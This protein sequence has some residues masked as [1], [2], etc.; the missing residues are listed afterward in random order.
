VLQN[1]DLDAAQKF[2]TVACT[3]SLT[4]PLAG[5]LVTTKTTLSVLLLVLLSLRLLWFVRQRVFGKVLLKH[6]TTLNSHLIDSTPALH[7]T[8]P[9]VVYECLIFVPRITGGQQSVHLLAEVERATYDTVVRDKPCL[10]HTGKRAYCITKSL[11]QPTEEALGIRSV[12][13]I[14]TDTEGL[15]SDHYAGHGSSNSHAQLVS[16]ATKVQRTGMGGI[17]ETSG[18]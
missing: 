6:C 5:D 1:H 18:A 17:F 8:K 4:V 7:L 9:N 13:L 3:S 10:Q 12:C 16:T 15:R 14:K 11:L 2:P